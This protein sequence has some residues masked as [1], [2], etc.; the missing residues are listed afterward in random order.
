ML[1]AAC[2]VSSLFPS[3]SPHL[4]GDSGQ[5]TARVLFSESDI[6]GSHGDIVST[7]E[8]DQSGGQP[9]PY[10]RVEKQLEYQGQA[11][12]YKE[13]TLPHLYGKS[14]ILVDTRVL[15]FSLLLSEQSHY[16]PVGW[17]IYWGYST[18]NGLV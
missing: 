15:G 10:R 17:T 14:A 5:Q 4:P 6:D 18:R 12:L 9:D 13:Q 16:W 2:T 3:L 11:G 1:H 8:V 7:D